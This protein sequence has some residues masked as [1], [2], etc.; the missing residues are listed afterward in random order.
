MLIDQ[1]VVQNHASKFIG[2]IL[3]YI[4]TQAFYKP[5]DELGFVLCLLAPW[6]HL[7]LPVHGGELCAQNSA[8]VALSWW[9]HMLHRTK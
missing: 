6:P 3:E 4:L 7:S 9:S 5:R 8:G 1:E 2:K